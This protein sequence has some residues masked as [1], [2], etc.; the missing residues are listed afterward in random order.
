MTFPSWYPQM[1]TAPELEQVFTTDAEV[2]FAIEGL[3]DKLSIYT[4]RPDT[5][6]GVSYMAVAAEHP[7]A[8]RAAEG[9]PRLA[10]FL[11]EWLRVADSAGHRARRGGRCV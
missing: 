4:T 3:E 7:L 2:D 10:A 1:V 11:R 8:L 6:M 9:D 5:L